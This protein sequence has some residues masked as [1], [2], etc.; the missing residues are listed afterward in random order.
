MTAHIVFFI[1][2]A[3]ALLGDARIFLFVMNRVV[4]GNHREEKSP[5]QPLLYI[6]PPV[7]LFLTLLFWPLHRWIAWFMER[8]FVE[9]VTPDPLERVIWWI[10]AARLG[11]GWLIG[12]ACVGVYWIVD[13]MRHNAHPERAQ[14]VRDGA[15]Q[16]IR[17]RKAHM[18]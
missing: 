2:V 16:V 7:L 13:R 18:P 15:P 14:G 4:F 1:L 10:P 17:I 3:F 5:W 8:P 12:A 9:R 11:A 6:T